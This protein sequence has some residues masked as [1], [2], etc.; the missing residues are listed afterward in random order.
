MCGESI[1]K[2][3][4][5]AS[6]AGLLPVPSWLVCALAFFSICATAVV[7]AGDPALAARAVER[8][9]PPGAGAAVHRDIARGFR[10]SDAGGP[11][12]AVSRFLDQEG[13][14]ADTLDSLQVVREMTTI[15]TGA[16][17]VEFAQEVDGLVVYGA[18]V[19]AIFDADGN[20][21]SVSERLT[22]AG[23]VVP[24][25]IDARAALEAALAEVHPGIQARLSEQGS[26]DDTVT[27]GGD[28][29]FFEDPT[30]THVVVPGPGATLAEGFL[31]ETWSAE[32][33]QLTHTLV[34]GTG[35]VVYVEDRTFEI[36]DSY[37]VYEQHPGASIQTP[38]SGPEPDS[39]PY[40]P[41]GWL[42]EGEPQWTV[43]IVGNN[44]WAYLD[45]DANN[46]ADSIEG[47]PLVTDGDFSA[48]QHD[49]ESAPGIDVNKEAAV[50]NLFYFNN[51]IHDDLYRYGFDENAGNFQYDND[52]NLLNGANGY[53]NMQ[54][55]AQD[56]GGFNN[57]N[58]SVPPDG[59][60]PRMQMY[61]W[62]AADPDRDS[63]L[64]G[65]VV[66]HEYGHGLT[67]RI[68]GGMGGVM[69]GAIGEGASDAIAIIKYDD[70]VVGEYSY[71]NANGIRNAPYDTYLLDTGR[72]YEDFVGA[73]H[74]DGEIYAAIMWRMWTNYRDDLD[75]AITGDKRDQVMQDIVDGMKLTDH[76]PV[77]GQPTF[78]FM[79]DG[80]LMAISG[81]ADP[82]TPPPVEAVRARWCY[83]WEAFAHFGV[84]VDQSTTFTF[85]WWV[86]YEDFTVPAA[87]DSSPPP[88]NTPPVAVADAATT[89]E[90]TPVTIDVLDNDSD[91][92]G[93]TLTVISVTQPV[94]GSAVINADDTV[95]Y[96]PVPDFNGANAFDYFISDGN[97][98]T[99]SATVSVTVDAV[100]DPP[101][102]DFD[103]PLPATVGNMITLDG[104]RSSDPEEDALTYSWTLDSWP[105]GW[106]Q[107][108]LF[109]KTSEA[110]AE[111]TAKKAGDHV[112]TLTVWDGTDSASVTKT[113][114]VEGSSGGGGGKPPC[115][116]N[117]NKTC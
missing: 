94:N 7:V 83:A 111:L 112:V 105:G 50:Q 86:W 55:E 95:T 81:L 93:D 66:W 70:D 49:P 76:E 106:K 56:G 72:T 23:P 44:V 20:L 19:K 53:D 58:I 24:A 77:T 38:V 11:R 115:K 104:T 82:F 26:A 5:K 39:A 9:V 34:D 98:E 63:A 27:F 87:C 36:H 25:A 6:V 1:F 29:F 92:E 47:W 41:F 80:I 71:D 74:D 10:A 32:A 67:V 110:M 102:A 2:R 31:V 28:D 13:W 33:N 68:I 57:A 37:N 100:N 101:V 62:T 96:T 90:D 8:S 17:V 30:V 12:G 114:V 107:A 91:P 48:T 42:L 117:K 40:S 79:R 43:D 51:D 85:P 69:G 64:D 73:V 35:K 21:Q 45:I 22:P 65:D 18:Y 16:R 116:A 84:G 59:F 14:D 60:R 113:I 99:A 78:P 75:N 88:N 54:A 15:G 109:E 103:W 61:I 89:V 46:V 97:G 3:S 108:P 4:R 52:G